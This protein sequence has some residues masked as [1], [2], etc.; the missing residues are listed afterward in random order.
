MPLALYPSGGEGMPGVS[1]SD[2]GSS[3]YTKLIS[4]L[5][6]EM[7]EQ[8]RRASERLKNRETGLEESHAR[9]LAE[10]ELSAEENI[11]RAKEQARESV[12]QEK[13]YSRSEL[14]ALKKQ[15]YDRNGRT[16]A[17]AETS[18]LRDLALSQIEESERDFEKRSEA[19]HS[20]VETRMKK[21]REQTDV[22]LRNQAHRMRQGHQ[23]QMKGLQAQ[24][25]DLIDADRRY[26]KEKGQGTADAIR[27]FEND[28][29]H[30]ERVAIQGYE[31]QLQQ[32]K[33]GTREQELYLNRLKDETLRDQNRYFAGVISEQNEDHQEQITQREAN[34]DRNIGE[35][36]KRMGHQRERHELSQ[37]RAADESG[38]RLASALEN[39][40]DAYQKTLKN[41]STSSRER[42]DELSNELNERKTSADTSLISPAAEAAIRKSAAEDHEKVLRAEQQRNQRGSDDVREEYVGRFKRAVRAGEYEKSALS[43]THAAEKHRQR[44]EFLSH[45]R[46]SEYLKDST[47]RAK[48][49]EMRRLQQTTEQRNSHTLEKQRQEYEAMLVSQRDDAVA[50][51]QAL[52]QET[53][54]N[55]KMA[56]RAFAI[57]QNEL[58][59]EYDRKLADQMRDYEAS[60]DE[61]KSQ[62]QQQ[63][64]DGERRNRQALD[65]Q[66]RFYEQRFAQLEVQHKERERVITQNYEQDLEKLRRS[67]ALLIQK[68]S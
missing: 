1:P 56:H 34:F 3:Y 17:E 43:R 60:L 18:R 53:E 42:I 35:L 54:F 40:A 57:R 38:R 58:I 11:R 65:E 51:I 13:A 33:Q 61:L 2:G 6:D 26:G 39:Q 8:S 5:E 27:Q 63:L 67:N 68:K 46:E 9:E 25:S 32:M 16:L 45:V 30:R 55:S 19:M 41:Q 59:R 52:R 66:E 49:E 47:L 50:R 23:F 14:D 28:W 37:E 64:R 7:R 62:T 36:E 12:L 24:V 15:N 29:R 10:Q 44:N 22:A 20:N 21:N 48:D 4:D 31:D